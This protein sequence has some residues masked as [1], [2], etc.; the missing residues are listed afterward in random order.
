MKLGI[1]Q[2]YFFPY[3]GYFQIMNAVNEFIVYDNIKYTKKGWLNRN[4]ILVEGRDAFITLPLKKDSDFLDVRDRYIA[5]TWHKERDRMLNR[6]HN[7]Y[8][9]SSQFHSVYP[10]VEKILYYED[11]NLFRFLYHSL[12][13]LKE[14]LNIR[15]SL[16]VSSTVPID[17]TLKNNHKVL[18][19]CKA[20]NATIY[21]NPISGAT[22]YGRENFKRQGINLLFIKTRNTSYAQHGAT[23]V[24]N[25]SIIDVMMF[26]D[27]EYIQTNL[28]EAY[29]LFEE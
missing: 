19:L 16:V 21:I 17:H 18:A 8:R 6:I 20:R 12:T 28:L 11:D 13:I 25:L 23:F 26:N 27:R 15:T 10:L 24:P 4:R 5:A 2:P 1:F 14:Y 9:A 29:D 7:S 22:L 3:I